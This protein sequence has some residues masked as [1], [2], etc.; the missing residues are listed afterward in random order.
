MEKLLQKFKLKEVQSNRVNRTT[1]REIREQFG[2]DAV[3]KGTINSHYFAPL[4]PKDNDTRMTIHLTVYLVDLNSF[5]T[6]ACYHNEGWRRAFHNYRGSD[7]EK[8]YKSLS[9]ISSGNVK[10]LVQLARSSG[11]L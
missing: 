1:L 6:V 11:H 5:E 10:G 9:S 7:P 2:A 3:V 4:Y 8:Y